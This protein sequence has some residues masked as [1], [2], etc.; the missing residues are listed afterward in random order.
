[1]KWN[2]YNGKGQATMKKLFSGKVLMYLLTI[3]TLGLM[4][5]ANMKWHGA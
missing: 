3:A 2:G 1:M 4:L 5:G